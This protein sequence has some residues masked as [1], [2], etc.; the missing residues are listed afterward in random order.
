MEGAE[1]AVYEI[2]G[3][4]ADGSFLY[5]EALPIDVWIT[6]KEEAHEILGLTAGRSYLLKELKA[7][8]G[9][10]LMEPILFAMS[11]DGCEPT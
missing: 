1:F 2:T 4:N 5:E 3:R 7:P 11:M 10:H 8:K 6:G 9:Y